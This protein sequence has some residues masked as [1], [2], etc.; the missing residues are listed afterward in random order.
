MKTCR[1]CGRD[2]S[3]YCGGTMKEC[4]NCWVIEGHLRDF[5]ATEQGRQFALAALGI[6]P[7]E[8]RRLAETGERRYIFSDP[9]IEAAAQA[10]LSLHRRLRA[11]EEVSSPPC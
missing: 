8:L 11:L 4:G 7:D 10:I 5:V 9:E 3:N 1:W 6:D 2:I